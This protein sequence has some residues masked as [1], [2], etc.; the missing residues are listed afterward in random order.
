[1]KLFQLLTAF[2]LW[3]TPAVRPA[4]PAPITDSK[5]IEWTCTNPLSTTLDLKVNWD[6]NVFDTLH[7]N[8]GMIPNISSDHTQPVIDAV[9]YSGG[10]TV[11]DNNVK[12]PGSSSSVQFSVTAHDD[13]ALQSATLYVD[14]F[15]VSRNNG[16]A[17]SLADNGK[18]F[19][20]RWNAA[21]IEPGWHEFT[22]GVCDWVGNCAIDKS[23]RMQK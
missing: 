3:Q 23:W 20:V 17:H 15:E 8:F 9:N 5:L 22:L 7:L 10:P 14:S 16:G 6:R 1:M 12:I 18:A 2:L 4:T 11:L 21:T 13:I 19:A